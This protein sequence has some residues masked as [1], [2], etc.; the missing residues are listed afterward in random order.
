VIALLA[1][2]IVLGTA[3]WLRCEGV[4]PEV[5]A[6]DAVAVGRH[7][8]TV[9]IEVVDADSGVRS[10][11]AVLRHAGGEALLLEERYP[12]NPV[13]GALAGPAPPPAEL[14]LEP[15]ALGLREGDAFLDVR[16]TDWSWARLLRGNETVLEVPVTVD[17]TAPRVQVESGLTYV[18]RGGAA[19]VAYRV[20]ESTTRDGVEVADAFF[21]GF[22]VPGDEGR[23]VA[24]FAIARD[25]PESPRVRVVAEDAAG[26]RTARGWPVRIQEQDF[27][28]VTINLSRGFM[29]GKVEE[30]SEILKIEGAD[31][32]ERFQKINRD[33]RAR[34]EARIREIVSGAD[35]ERVWS[36]AFEQMRNSAVTSRFAEH[37][38][39]F[40]EGEK[41]SEAIHYG[42]DLAS[43]AGAPI[44]AA[45]AGRVLFA[46]EL[47]IYGN[48]VIL[49]HGLGLSSLYAHLS[50]I[51]VAVGDRVEKGQTLGLS[52]QTG[53]AGGDHLHFAILVS[54]TY[55]DPKEWWDPKWVREHVEARLAP[56]P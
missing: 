51:D 54:G 39:Y 1:I 14:R 17:L 8:A 6:P 22:P 49:D 10:V 9:V 2:A 3:L 48:C 27:D 45:A 28:D 21:P 29:D 4:P 16:A 38:S 18:R 15:E 47:G 40:L 37:R 46:S 33:V 56:A 55:V 42:Y 24:L 53:L 34:N 52:G 26:N 31:S 20:G 43:L 13:T 25:A 35:G 7:G 50:R 36:G 32:V 41:I 11:E 12:G 19:A 30:L 5:H 23:R 44:E